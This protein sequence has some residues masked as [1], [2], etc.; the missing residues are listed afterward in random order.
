MQ[1]VNLIKPEKSSISYSISRFPD[2]EVQITLGEFS[3]KDSVDVICRITNPEELFILMQVCD[4]LH[5]H[6]VEFEISIY[7]LMTMRMDRVMDFNRPFS[8]SIVCNVLDNL[9]ARFIGIFSPHSNAYT[10]LLKKTHSGEIGSNATDTPDIAKYQ[11]VIPDEGAEERYSFYSDFY[12]SD[13]VICSK[14][15]DLKTGKITS[16]KI[17]NPESILGKPLLILDDL[18]DGGGTFVGIAE[19]IRKIR[20]DVN[21]NIY[22]E[23]MV[24]PRGIENLSKNFDRVWF[25]NSYKDWRAVWEH[26]PTPFP[27][28][29][30][31]IDVV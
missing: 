3:H 19:A 22:V 21:L 25:T 4:I 26:Q 27:K 5:R 29:V 18:C 11:L 17:N 24:N 14:V 7:Y 15:R 8:L 10:N 1:T 16:I 30:T 12:S 28:N 31:Q 2:G 23:H 6:G 20:P 9:G 13:L